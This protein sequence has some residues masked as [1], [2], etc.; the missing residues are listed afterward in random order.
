MPDLSPAGSAPLWEKGRLDLSVEAVVLQ[1]RF[2]D[3][4]TDEELTTAQDRLAE[5]GY[6]PPQTS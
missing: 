6:H 2:A 3:L 1:D 4:F 5:Y